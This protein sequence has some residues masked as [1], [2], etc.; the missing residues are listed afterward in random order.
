MKSIN[1]MKYLKARQFLANSETVRTKPRTFSF[2]DET[3]AELQRLLGPKA[4]IDCAP[5]A[6]RCTLGHRAVSCSP[7]SEDAESGTKLNGA[8]SRTLLPLL[9]LPS[10]RWTM[11]LGSMWTL[12]ATGRWEFE[13]QREGPD[14]DLEDF[15]AHAQ[16][17]A[18]VLDWLLSTQKTARRAGHPASQT[19]GRSWD[20]AWQSRCSKPVTSSRRAATASWRAPF[21]YC[22]TWPTS[23]LQRICLIPSSALSGSR[24]DRTASRGSGREGCG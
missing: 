24:R 16:R 14:V 13:H 12:V 17:I 8:S 1:E 23:A 6:Q 10:I 7:S 21:R 19:I 2:S 18:A 9:G 15:A 3:R 22:S 4:P 11:T 5:G 20:L